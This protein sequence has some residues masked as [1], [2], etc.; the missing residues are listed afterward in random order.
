MKKNTTAIRHSSYD[1]LDFVDEGLKS[2]E[3]KNEFRTACAKAVDLLDRCF[4]M[5]NLNMPGCQSI[6]LDDSYESY[7]IGDYL[8][9][10]AK[11]YGATVIV[12]RE[13]A[14][15]F[16]SGHWVIVVE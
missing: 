5:A 4:S 6:D 7:V 3:F 1:M 16:N 9:H 12:N 14:E 11:H 13:I 10:F 15:K 8:L 2:S